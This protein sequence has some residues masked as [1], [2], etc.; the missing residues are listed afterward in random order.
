MTFLEKI[1]EP[2]FWSSFMKVTI[3]FFV[4][5]V[6]ISL[7]MNSASDI[8]SGNF[9]NVSEINFGQGKWVSFFGIK[10]VISVVYGCYITN[11]N[12]K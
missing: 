5:V 2:L 12:M 1:K 10:I 3:P 11:K 8:F 6:L 9:S 4:M 7:V